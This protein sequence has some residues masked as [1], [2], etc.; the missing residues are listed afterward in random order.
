[1]GVVPLQFLPGQSA[2][3]LGL[4]G[5]EIYSVE[6]PEAPRTHELVTVKVSGGAVPSFQVTARFDT[7][8]DLTYYRHGGILNYMIRKMIQE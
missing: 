2:A 6:I 3:S 8:V 7:E 1:M 4:T 5:E